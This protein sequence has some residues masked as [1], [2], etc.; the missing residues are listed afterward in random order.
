MRGLLYATF[1]L[2]FLVAPVVN[3][4]DEAADKLIESASEDVQSAQSEVHNARQNYLNAVRTSGKESPQ[5]ASA[6]A[7]LDE[8]RAEWHN[9]MADRQEL[10]HQARREL[11]K[12]RDK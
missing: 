10:R 11:M 5:A 9:K 2:T 4:E 3:A 8:A 1:A 12:E 6:K 7:R